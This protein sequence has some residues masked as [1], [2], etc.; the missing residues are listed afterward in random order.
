MMVHA[1]RHVLE[2]GCPHVHALEGS[3]QTLRV[4]E[5]HEHRRRRKELMQPQ[6]YAICSPQS[7]EPVVNEGNGD[8]FEA[9]GVGCRASDHR[10]CAVLEIRLQVGGSCCPTRRPH[11]SKPRDLR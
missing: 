6:E 7:D 5:R 4:V 9:A 1:P 3:R 2:P 10:T 8:A 11:L